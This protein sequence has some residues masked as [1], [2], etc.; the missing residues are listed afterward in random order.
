M[1]SVEVRYNFKKNYD[2]PQIVPTSSLEKNLHEVKVNHFHKYPF[3]LFFEK[4][5][6]FSSQ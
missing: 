2:R 1:N 4:L 3:S 6:Y 5:T